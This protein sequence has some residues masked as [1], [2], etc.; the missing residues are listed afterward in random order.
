MLELLILSYGMYS[1]LFQNTDLTSIH[2]HSKTTGVA[3]LGWIKRDSAEP[4]N[5]LPV[6]QGESKTFVAG[7][8]PRFASVRRRPLHLQLT[9]EMLASPTW[10]R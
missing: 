5:R 6:A 3:S 10:R 4:P 2:A 7:D 1:E 9:Y 8:S